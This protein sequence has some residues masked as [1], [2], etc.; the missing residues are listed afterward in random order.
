MSHG[1]EAW[2]AEKCPSVDK[3][4]SER[5]ISW[6]CCAGRWT[7]TARG[8]E[9]RSRSSRPVLLAV[10]VCSSNLLSSGCMTYRIKQKKRA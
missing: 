10:Q 3:T 8:G 2:H 5:E 6:W 4:W 7:G 9:K 1:R